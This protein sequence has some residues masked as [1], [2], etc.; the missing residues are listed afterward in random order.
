MTHQEATLVSTSHYLTKGFNTL[1]DIK[2]I[3]DYKT[4]AYEDFTDDGLL[5]EIQ[6]LIDTL[7]EQTKEVIAKDSIYDLT[8]YISQLE[9]D[10]NVVINTT[11]L[12]LLK[13][14][15]LDKERWYEI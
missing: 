8:T 6:S 5:T 12:H 15:Y 3:G 13:E 2:H 4:E 1:T 9:E 11:D 10:I 14:C 7:T